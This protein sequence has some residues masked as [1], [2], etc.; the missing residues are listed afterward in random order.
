MAC[1]LD[2]LGHGRA[3]L[4]STAAPMHCAS[5]PS[6]PLCGIVITLFCLGRMEGS[7]GGVRPAV[8]HTGGLPL[9]Q[10]GRSFASI[11]SGCMNALCAGWNGHAC[12]PPD[13]NVHGEVSRCNTI[14]LM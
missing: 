4:M 12:E 10:L 7:K 2:Q 13:D 5:G 8:W 3:T 1:R 14:C 6:E 11:L 9:P